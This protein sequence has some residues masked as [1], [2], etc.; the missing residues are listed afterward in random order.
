MIFEY[1]RNPDLSSISPVE[2][3]DE[4]FDQRLFE[5]AR[6]LGM[7]NDRRIAR[8]V[9]G[10]RLLL[11]AGYLFGCLAPSL[12]DVVPGERQA[13]LLSILYGDG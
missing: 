11:V 3:A 7:G 10:T 4:S 12:Q 8:R 6:C 5:T 2:A 9:C 1:C 13:W